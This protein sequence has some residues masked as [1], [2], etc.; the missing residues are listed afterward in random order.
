[1][2]IDAHLDF[3]DQRHGVR[4]GH[5]N[6]MRRCLEM[7]RGVRSG[8]TLFSRIA[9]MVLPPTLGKPEENGGLMVVNDGILSGL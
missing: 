8:I 4:F 7:C 1:M 3:V 9:T 5:G 2:Q 6:S